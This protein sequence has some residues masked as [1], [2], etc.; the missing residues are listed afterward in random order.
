MDPNTLSYSLPPEPVSGSLLAQSTLALA[1]AI[2]FLLAQS[3]IDDDSRLELSHGID[4]AQS[5]TTTT[6]DDEE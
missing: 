2:A 3:F 5:S 4:A 1:V 6:N